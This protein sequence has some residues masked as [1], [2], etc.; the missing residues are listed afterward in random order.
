MTTSQALD[1]VEK[2]CGGQEGFHRVWRFIGDAWDK[3]LEDL[4]LQR[5]KPEEYVKRAKVMLHAYRVAEFNRK[6][7]ER[8]VNSR[9]RK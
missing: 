6:F 7:E 4:C 5:Q 8:L 1:A 2:L 3:N 9:E